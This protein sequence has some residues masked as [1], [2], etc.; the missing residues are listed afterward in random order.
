MHKQIN[1]DYAHAKWPHRKPGNQLGT[2]I[3][4]FL[5]FSV[6]AVVMALSAVKADPVINHDV[7]GVTTDNLMGEEMAAFVVLNPGE[8]EESDMQ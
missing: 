4:I 1:H 3:I 2:W 8:Y 6:G 7:V 5:I